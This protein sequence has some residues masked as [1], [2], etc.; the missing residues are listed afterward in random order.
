MSPDQEGKSLV[1][2]KAPLGIAIINTLS[3]EI[4][5]ANDSYCALLQRKVG[6]VIG[7]TWMHFTHQDDVALNYYSVYQM[8][9]RKAPRVYL[10]KRY[11][12]PN[13]EV[14]HACLTMIPF[15]DGVSEPT[16]LIMV[17]DISNSVHISE[18]LKHKK[19]ELRVTREEVLNA[20][21]VVARFRDRET[22]D[23]LWR[24]RSYMRLLLSSMKKTQPFS[25]QGI[26]TIASAS[27]LHDI[28]KIGIPDSILLKEGRLD[29]KEKKIMETHTRLGADA[30]VETMRHLSG[31][32]ALVYAREIAE[33]HHER[34]DGGGY[35]YGLA[36]SE[37]PLTARAMAIADVYDAL[38]SARPY[39]KPFLHSDS[40][41]IIRNE[42]GR[43]FDPDLVEVFLN[44]EREFEKV[45]EAREEATCSM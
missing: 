38:R 5:S 41:G 8:Y 1:F 23:H 7:K 27:M 10:K 17:Q 37:I 32:V 18:E 42:A 28:G 33:Y 15:N 12:S 29:D 30:I 4:L 9:E 19:E 40:V 25:R 22:G 24:T 43:H 16:H 20:L 11:I 45:S 44:K 36:G 13:G 14:I 26:E 35:P 6:Q 39:K 21:V 34:W 2:Q 3:G 31:D